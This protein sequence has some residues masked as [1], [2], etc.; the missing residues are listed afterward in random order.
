VQF[1][2]SMQTSSRRSETAPTSP[3]TSVSTVSRV[4]VIV[5]EMRGF[6]AMRVRLARRRNVRWP[7]KGGASRRHGAEE[8]RPT[9][10]WRSA[11]CLR[12]TTI[13]L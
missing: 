7:A 2:R 9:S 8:G 10:G 5:G 4:K 13:G 11:A 6:R 3:K 12:L 1:A